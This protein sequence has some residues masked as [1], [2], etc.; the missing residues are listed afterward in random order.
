MLVYS[1]RVNGRGRIDGTLAFYSREA[2]GPTK[3]QLRLLELGART[4]AE[5]L[6]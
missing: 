5:L 2:G 6:N 3:R 1:D 4:A